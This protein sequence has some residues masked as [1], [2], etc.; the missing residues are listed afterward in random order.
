ML[1]RYILGQLF[2][3]HHPLNTKAERFLFTTEGHVIPIIPDL[4][5]PQWNEKDVNWRRIPD[6]ELTRQP[7]PVGHL[8]AMSENGSLSVVSLILSA[9]I[10]V[11]IVIIDYYYVLF[12]QCGM[13]RTNSL[14]LKD[15]Y[16]LQLFETV[17]AEL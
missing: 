9:I 3:I 12:V 17:G 8:K 13:V 16:L 1:L 14:P 4:R 6:S 10:I 15:H 5:S 11:I 2:D 7:S